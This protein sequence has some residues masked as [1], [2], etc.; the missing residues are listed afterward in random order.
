[1]SIG[2][3]PGQ[4]PFTD[5]PEWCY[6]AVAWCYMNG[7]TGGVGGGLFGSGYACTRAQIVTFL[8]RQHAG[9]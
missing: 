4:H 3:R 1:M 5:V 8:Y 7:I 9:K 6:E 2:F